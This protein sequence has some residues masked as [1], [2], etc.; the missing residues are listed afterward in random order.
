[1]CPEVKH[2][3]KLL[4]LHFDTAMQSSGHLRGHII[5]HKDAFLLSR[6]SNSIITYKAI[7]SQ[8]NFSDE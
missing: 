1:M 8:V 3:W 5:Y 4:V 7:W 6:P 2:A